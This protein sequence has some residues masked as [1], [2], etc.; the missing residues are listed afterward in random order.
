LDDVEMK[1]L[2]IKS[3]TKEKSPELPLIVVTSPEYQNERYF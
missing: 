3:N 1:D 2:S